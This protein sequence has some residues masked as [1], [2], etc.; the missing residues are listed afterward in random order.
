MRIVK[1]TKEGVEKF[2][3]NAGKSL[4]TF[5]YFTKRPLSAIENH[6][7]TLLALDG[8]TPIGYGHLDK[9]EN[10]RIWLGVCVSEAER[11]KGIGTTLVSELIDHGLSNEV[12]L[13]VDASN[14]PAHKVYE[15]IGFVF[16]EKR[17]ETWFYKRVTMCPICKSSNAV[18]EPP[19]NSFFSDM[20]IRRMKCLECDAVFG[21]QS[22]LCMSAK[23]LSEK[24]HELYSRYSEGDTLQYELDTFSSIN[25]NPSGKY[26]DFGCGN[27]RTIDMLR[28]KGINIVGFDPIVSGKN[29]HSSK[30]DL[31]GEYDGIF[32]HNVI[33]HLQDPVKELRW[34]VGK[35]RPGGLMAHST[36][37]F[38]YVHEQSEYHLVFLLGRSKH[39]LLDKCG[40]EYVEFSDR[41][42]SNESYGRLLARKPKEVSSIT[43][44]N[45]KPAIMPNPK[46]KVGA[47]M[48]CYKEADMA[49]LNLR[50]FYPLV[51]HLVVIIGPA[52]GISEEEDQQTTK[53]L[54][55]V[56]DKDKKITLISGV[57]KDKNEMTAKAV[58]FLGKRCDIICQVDADEFWPAET[59]REAISRIKNGAVQVRIPHYIFWKGTKLI[60]S[61]NENKFY[62]C[63][64]RVFKTISGTHVTHLPPGIF[65]DGDGKEYQGSEAINYN[66]LWHF[67]WITSDQVRR[68]A[69]YYERCGARIFSLEDFERSG[70][71]SIIPNEGHPFTIVRY[72]GPPMDED[73][74]TYFGGTTW[75]R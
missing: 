15:R 23:S 71:G 27:Q 52:A 3:S 46:P 64:P 18:P 1:A 41:K 35:M 54:S 65:N 4:E 21:P 48:L 33:E 8:D 34:M 37:C 47:Y 50:R 55:L 12:W 2:L 10:G 30:D 67:G 60:C 62:F 11:G 19:K 57:W 59:F 32:S 66:P 49:S 26:L 69:A 43:I 56:D 16:Q 7:L 5:R 40:L 36:E 73:L 25:T 28:A 24:Y 31:L 38:S 22:W 20:I 58:S 72:D 39:V 63:P 53:A 42:V 75:T 17:Q 74:E 51:D 70:E 13:S 6:L 45:L 68:K 61:S 29:I 44:P 14:L 9:D